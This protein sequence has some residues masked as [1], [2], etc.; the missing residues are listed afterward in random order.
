MSS[1]CP[2]SSYSTAVTLSTALIFKTNT[3]DKVV[4][5]LTSYYS[6]VE[7]LGKTNL[8]VFNASILLKK[9]KFNFSQLTTIWRSLESE[10]SVQRF[11][12]SI[13]NK[14]SS[15]FYDLLLHC[16]QQ[17][18]SHRSLHLSGDE[19]VALAGILLQ[20]FKVNNI[21]QNTVYGDRLIKNS[22]LI[23]CL[24]PT[25]SANSPLVQVTF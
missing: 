2:V 10:N 8:V 13:I 25:V 18:Y 4:T 17:P 19:L 11:F 16:M 22:Q 12:N 3:R 5:T 24:F 15:I 14:H 21:Y 1:P 9:S 6:D 7:S 23:E 20:L